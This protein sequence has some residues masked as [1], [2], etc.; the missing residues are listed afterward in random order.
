M[1][2]C[3][4]R[5]VFFS[6]TQKVEFLMNHFINACCGKTN[7]RSIVKNNDAQENISK[8]FTTSLSRENQKVKKKEKT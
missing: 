8:N 3:V 4:F 2:V 6:S 1:M 5:V 7:F